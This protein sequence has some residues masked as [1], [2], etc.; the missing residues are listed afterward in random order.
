MN[1]SKKYSLSLPIIDAILPS[2]RLHIENALNLIIEKGHREVGFLLQF[3]DNT[4]DL[5]ESPIVELIERLLGKGYHLSVYDK[6]VNAARLHGKIL[7]PSNSAFLILP[8]S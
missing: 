4:D 5:R 1:A 3:Q 6:N 8:T 7:K 2:N